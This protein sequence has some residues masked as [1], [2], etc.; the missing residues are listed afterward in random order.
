MSKQIFHS[1]K[2][3]FRKATTGGEDVATAVAANQPSPAPQ[4]TEDV[5]RALTE[6]TAE[7]SEE[8]AEQLQILS[9]TEEEVRENRI[10]RERLAYQTSVVVKL[11]SM[12][13]AAG[14]GSYRV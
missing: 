11:G 3:R 8:L 2:N 9:L 5:I 4:P 6:N 14:A 10:R 12:L 1:F 7:N 13:M